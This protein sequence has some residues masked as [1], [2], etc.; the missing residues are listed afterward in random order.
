MKPRLAIAL[1]GVTL[2]ATACSDESLQPQEGDGAAGAGGA[3]Y[4]PIG[5]SA[6]AAEDSVI[7]GTAGAAGAGGSAGGGGPMEVPCG[8]TSCKAS[9][10]FGSTTVAGCCLAPGACGLIPP[11]YAAYV[12]SHECHEVN[13]PTGAG[14][15]CPGFLYNRFQLPIPGCCRA[16]GVCGIVFGPFG[17]IENPSYYSRC[18]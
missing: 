18:D 12:L 16:D 15:D 14:T 10:P 7:G 8:D 11:A 4:V 9:Q 6:G 3:V 13:Q 2:I 5:G 1:I 17:C